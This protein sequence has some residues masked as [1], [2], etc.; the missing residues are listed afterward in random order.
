MVNNSSY[1]EVG[2]KLG[3]SDNAVRKRIKTRISIDT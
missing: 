2:K 3:V 1:V